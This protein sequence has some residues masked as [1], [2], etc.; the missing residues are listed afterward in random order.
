MQKITSKQNPRIKNLL[1]L[2]RSRG[3]KKQN[4]IAIF[5]AREIIRALSCGVVADEIFVCESQ[6]NP[7]V[8]SQI[9]DLVADFSVA[10]SIDEEVFAKVC[11]GE[12]HDGLIMTAQRPDQSIDA[13]FEQLPENALVTVVESIEKPG[14][15]GAILRSADGAAVDAVIVADPQTDWFHPNAIRSSLGTS[16]SM[17]GCVTPST[18]IRDRLLSEG[19]Q[20]VVAALEGANDFYEFDLT[21]KSAIVLGNEAGGVTDVWKQD[22]MRAAKLPMLGIADSLNV[23]ATAAAMFYEARRQRQ[24]A[25]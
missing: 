20:I 25:T 22:S 4:R 18:I 21:G 6:A 3:R 24:Q 8:V 10:W 15:L 17:L 13:V 9:K 19:Y 23:S 1:L 7:A 12:R 14:N 5:G 11:F 2:H 16:F